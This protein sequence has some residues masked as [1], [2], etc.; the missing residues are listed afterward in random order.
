MHS[1]LSLSLYLFCIQ[2]AGPS[3]VFFQN[4]PKGVLA[5]RPLKTNLIASSNATIPTSLQVIEYIW[6]L[7]TFLHNGK[8]QEKKERKRQPLTV[9]FLS[10]RILC[11]FSLLPLPHK[12]SS[13]AFGDST[14]YVTAFS[15]VPDEAVANKITDDLVSNKLVAC[16][17]IIPGLK[18]AYWWKGEVVRDN[19]L[20]LMMKT[21]V[22]LVPKLTEKLKALHPYE[23]PELIVQPIIGGNA[24][25][26]S[27]I[28][29]STT[30]SWM[31]GLTLVCC[32]MVSCAYHHNW[33]QPLSLLLHQYDEYH[34]ISQKLCVFKFWSS[35]SC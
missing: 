8:K 34:S 32:D 29:E 5:K 20:L 2:Y 12:S 24:D 13:A 35:S 14:G 27:W 33:Q 25:Y 11:S 22:E 7:F 16:V 21:R 3:L 15:T 4:I 6:L 10:S 26:L 18:S 23:V 1:S 28:G 17:N 9:L 30:S 19:E 31:Y